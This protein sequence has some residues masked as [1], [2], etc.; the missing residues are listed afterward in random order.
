MMGTTFCVETVPTYAANCKEAP[1][2]DL[3]VLPGFDSTRI[4]GRPEDALQSFK[5][6][7]KSQLGQSLKRGAPF[8]VFYSKPSSIVATIDGFDAFQGRLSYHMVSGSTHTIDICREHI[9]TLTLGEAMEGSAPNVFVDRLGELHDPTTLLLAF[10]PQLYC[11]EEFD[12][13]PY[14]A[15]YL[16]MTPGQ[17]VVRLTS[18]EVSDWAFGWLEGVG[19][20]WYPPMYVA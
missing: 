6:F 7:C 1:A 8:T 19:A 5:S 16:S 18:P 17:A 15:E 11:Q 20:G 13:V 10:A 4:R 12:G 2:E 14:G 9:C 3:I